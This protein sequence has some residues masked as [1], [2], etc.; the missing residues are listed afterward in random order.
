[1][2][3][4]RYKNVPSSYIV[5]IKDSKVLLQ[6]RCNTGYE[7]GNYGIPAGHV[8]S[9][10]SFTK[11]LIREIKEE[12]GIDLNSED[13]KVAHMM[14]RYA[15]ENNER[16]DA[17]FIA[18]KWEGKIENKEPEKCDDLSWFDI[19]NLP[20]NVI[21][22]VRQAIDCINKKVFYSEHGWK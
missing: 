14:H 3:K 7:D 13:V 16:V 1:M 17:F 20:E 19:N 6:R 11:G 5:L 10:E 9:G 15:G 12:I 21:P 8:E 2:A 22:Y 18:E 4:E